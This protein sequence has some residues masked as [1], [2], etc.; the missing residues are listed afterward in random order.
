MSFTPNLFGLATISLTA[1]LFSLML[2]GC[3]SSSSPYSI[4]TT[5]PDSSHEASVGDADPGDGAGPGEGTDA[6][7]GKEATEITAETS[8]PCEPVCG[9]QEC[10][11]DGCG[12]YCGKCPGATNCVFGTCQAGEC[13]DITGAYSV[14]VFCQGTVACEME[15][16]IIQNGCLWADSEAVVFGEISPAGE[17]HAD[18]PHEILKMAGCAGS[19]P[20]EGQMVLECIGE[21]TAVFVLQ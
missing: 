16:D 8:L 14:Q 10:G 17:V 20:A 2:A 21:C 11:H 3:D 18:C 9:N 7:E 4:T 19:L 13:A 15:L 1:F 6:T 12:G 5:F